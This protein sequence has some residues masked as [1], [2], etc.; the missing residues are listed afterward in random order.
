MPVQDVFLPYCQDIRHTSDTL[1]FYVEHDFRFHQR[2]DESPR[3]WLPLVAGEDPLDVLQRRWEPI[4]GT[5]DLA[6]SEMAK[7]A[8]GI[9]EKLRRGRFGSLR[10]PVRRSTNDG[11][12]NDVSP[13]FCDCT[14]YCNAA[15]KKG[16]AAAISCGSGGMVATR[17]P[18]PD[19][20]TPRTSPSAAS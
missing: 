8:G 3:D 12:P 19:P 7:G 1:F 18:G 15:A 11:D 2:D 20:N 6:C 10:Q 4:P 5:E 13:E 14:A 16:R 9:P 17:M